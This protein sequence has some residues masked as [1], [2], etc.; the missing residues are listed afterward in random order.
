MMCRGLSQKGTHF[1]ILGALQICQDGTQIT[2]GAGRQRAILALLLLHPNEIVSCDRLI[3]ELWGQAPPVS[4]R[5][6]IQSL[7]SR[8]RRLLEAAGG[9]RQATP[10]VRRLNGYQLEVADGALGLFEFFRFI[11]QARTAA[12]GGRVVE[13][14]RCMESALGLWRGE[15]LVDVPRTPTIVWE[16]A[17]LE[18]ARVALLED[19]LAG[20]LRLGRY[21]DVI[22]ESRALLARHPLR[23]RL[24]A[25]LVAALHGAGR[26]GEALAVFRTARDHMI[27]EL[28]V[29]PGPELRRLHQEVLRF[30][31]DP[32][33]PTVSR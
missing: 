7:V 8:L 12:E 17:R 5:G 14:V 24:W 15:V 3:D 25:H 27:S 33:M 13:S 4:A 1:R 9:V 31:Q 28:G 6:T 16:A 30:G 10:L 21:N 23:E 18:E 22:F 2:P 11:R 29:E 26:Q 20:C 19:Y 32:D